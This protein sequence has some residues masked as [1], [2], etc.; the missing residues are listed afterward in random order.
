MEIINFVSD[1]IGRIHI[2][3]IGSLCSPPF[4]EH[5][6]ASW[7]NDR[8]SIIFKIFALCKTI[9]CEICGYILY[10]IP[11]CSIYFKKYIS[12]FDV[13]LPVFV[14]FSGTT[15]IVM[16]INE[17]LYSSKLPFPCYA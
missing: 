2:G 9:R 7:T 11:D 10:H 14:C 13:L 5:C 16:Q 3:T 1:D 17:M 12:V 8:G 6:F 4:G 15:G